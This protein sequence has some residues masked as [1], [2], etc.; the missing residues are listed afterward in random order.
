MSKTYAEKKSQICS[1]RIERSCLE[2]EG[3]VFDR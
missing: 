2:E 1:D 3:V